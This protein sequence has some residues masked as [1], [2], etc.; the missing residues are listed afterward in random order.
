VT[1]HEG[2]GEVAALLANMAE[3]RARGASSWK[4]Q[5][6]KKKKILL[7]AGALILLAFTYG[8]NELRLT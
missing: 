3:L 5:F 1:K 4:V 6:L 8:V 2:R 7:F